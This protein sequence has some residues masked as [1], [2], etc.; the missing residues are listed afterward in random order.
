MSRPFVVLLDLA[1]E[2]DPFNVAT[3]LAQLP[4]VKDVTVWPSKTW[5]SQLVYDSL[6]DVLVDCSDEEA[7]EKWKDEIND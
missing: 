6:E 4:G 2:D 1:D 5:D 3:W 7:V